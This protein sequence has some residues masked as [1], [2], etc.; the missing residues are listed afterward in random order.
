MLFRSKL[1][2]TAVSLFY[3]QS[4]WDYGEELSA[5]DYFSWFLSTTLDEDQ[6]YKEEH[7]AHPLGDGYGWFFPQDL[8]EERESPLC[9]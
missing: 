1:V 6:A 2:P 8:F 5:T 4:S 9:S 3:R 7:Y